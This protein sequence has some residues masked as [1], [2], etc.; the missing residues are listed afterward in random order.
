M[1]R[2]RHLIIDPQVILAPMSGITDASFRRLCREEGARL[3]CT[4]MVSANAVSFHSQKSADLLTFLPGE[5]P[6]SAQVFG[7]DP[8][9]VAEAAG[10]AERRGADIVDINMGCAVPKVL[11][12]GSGVALMADPERAEAMVR[13]AVAVVRI[14]VSVKIRRG[15]PDRGERAAA[16]AR[17]CENA[18]AAAVA[19]HPRWAQ[20][21]FGEPADWQVIAELKQ[22]VGI[23]V[24]GSGDIRSGADGRRMM[25][26]T[27][28]D[29][30][31][32]GR[33]ALGYPWIFREVAAALQGRPNPAP[34]SLEERL[35]MAARHAELVVADR[36]EKIGVRE[37]RKHF[38]WYLKAMP[39]ARSL[40][41]RANR[42]TT[43][44][45]LLAVLD[46]GVGAQHAVPL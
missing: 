46:G 6:V 9:I 19:V 36:G 7:A 14:P 39:G 11:R 33:A 27:G 40:R 23:P 8:D 42:A 18:G 38:A 20:E 5:H 1:M 35:A 34:P 28:C 30:V 21:Q 2:L 10:E 13:A 29:A 43:K 41:D 25:E 15:W 22:A 12:A 37:M 31:M 3:V 16:F 17:R 24:I 26:E 44:A 4:G 45:E 32:V